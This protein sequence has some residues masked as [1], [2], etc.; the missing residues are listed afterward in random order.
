MPDNTKRYEHAFSNVFIN[1]EERIR[2]IYDNPDWHNY[3]DDWFRYVTYR[4]SDEESDSLEQLMEW[5]V[6][7][8]SK[9]VRYAGKRLRKVF[10][11]LPPVEQR[12]VGLALLNGSQLDKE[13]VCR[14][15]DNRKNNFCDDWIVKW[16]P[17]YS[18][19]IKTCWEKYHGKHCG[20]IAVLFLD[21]DYIRE[22]V[23]EFKTEDL[24]LRLCKRFV[25]ESWFVVDVDLLKKST[26]I[27]AYLFIMSQTQHGITAE[28]ARR[29]LY[30]WVVTVALCDGSHLFQNYRDHVFWNYKTQTH[31]VIHAPGLSAALYYIL[32]MGFH[33][34]VK[35]FLDWDIAVCET[36][37]LYLYPETEDSIQNYRLF[38]TAILECIPEDLNY[39]TKVNTGS[40]EYIST[41]SQP[42]TEPRYNGYGKLSPKYLSEPE[43]TCSTSQIGETAISSSKEKVKSDANTLQSLLSI[44]PELKEL[45]DTLGLTESVK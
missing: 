17:C 5:F 23:D 13:W 6:D 27:G 34:V 31:S 1:D 25:N 4:P 10:P 33:E 14:H 12:N 28:E 37:T 2:Y 18:D 19:S 38:R 35:D 9:R 8:R 11:Y 26:S 44:K 42:Y 15:L 32:K 22:H 16:H 29:L 39:L 24:Y 20:R 40:Y 7:K 43:T 36:F 30:Q 21:E 3:S 45:I 41:V